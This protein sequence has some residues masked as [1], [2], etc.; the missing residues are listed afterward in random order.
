M[1]TKLPNT[2]RSQSTN[3]SYFDT[4][5]HQFETKFRLHLIFHRRTT[6]ETEIL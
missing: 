1:T 4:K 2:N 6:N 5:I 3:L